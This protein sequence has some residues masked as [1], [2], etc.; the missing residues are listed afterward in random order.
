M[1]I[2][3]ADD[4]LIF[5]NGLKELVKTQINDCEIIE[6]EDGEQALTM[7]SKH[8]PQIAI[9]DIDMPKQNGL[10]VCK[11]IKKDELETKVIILTM[12]KNEGM[13]I[14][15][16]ENGAMGYILKDNSASDLVNCINQVIDNKSFISPKI[17]SYMTKFDS[18]KNRKN[19][20]IEG[21]NKLTQT[22]LKTLKLV[23]NNLS[24]KEI[25]EMLF[26]TQKTVENYRS[27]ICKKAA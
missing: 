20:I 13:F 7:V 4:H 23:S 16:M 3:I 17:E 27:R 15:A 8:H 19:E 1:K 5:R 10:E 21:L 24:S 2:L 6:A 22:E 25:S 9:I 12:H 26:V 18:F 14:S 11:T